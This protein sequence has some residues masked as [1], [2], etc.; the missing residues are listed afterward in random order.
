MLWCTDDHDA[1]APLMVAVANVSSLQEWRAATG[2]AA[3]VLG[4][5]EI[6]SA[7]ICGK[8]GVRLLHATIVL[9]GAKYLLGIRGD[10]RDN[11][12]TLDGTIIHFADLEPDQLAPW[13]T[14]PWMSHWRNAYCPCGLVVSDLRLF[15]AG[16]GFEVALSRPELRETLSAPPLFEC[17][18]IA[19]LMVAVGGKY[20]I[21]IKMSTVLLNSYYVLQSRSFDLSV[22]V[23]DGIQ[24][25]SDWAADR[26]VRSVTI[27]DYWYSILKPCIQS[28]TLTAEDI[29]RDKRIDGRVAKANLS[30]YLAARGHHFDDVLKAWAAGTEYS[31]ETRNG[32]VDASASEIV[33]PSARPRGWQPAKSAGRK[34]RLSRD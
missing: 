2:G 12:A 28:G 17:D 32:V 15:A 22:P 29:R 11:P 18:A 9:N 5:L 14:A 3:F 34:P 30:N 19:R 23:P 1:R 25:Y 8:N 20:D 27:W 33:P 4:D 13:M 31:F 21:C 10:Y 16:W 7:H 24:S 6:T 26:P